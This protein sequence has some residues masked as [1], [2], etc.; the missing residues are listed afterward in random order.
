MTGNRSRNP[1]RPDI[2][3][4]NYLPR[5]IPL[6]ANTCA[7]LSLMRLLTGSSTISLDSQSLSYILNLVVNPYKLA[8][9]LTASRDKTFLVKSIQACSRHCTLKSIVYTR[10]TAAY[11]NLGIQ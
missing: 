9:L 7:Y 2:V 8:L 1:L 6:E 4:F 5:Q 11:R 3:F 10:L